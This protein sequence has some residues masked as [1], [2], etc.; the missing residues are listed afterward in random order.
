MKTYKS[1]EACGIS[2]AKV[3]KFVR[4][5]N[6]NGYAMHSVMLSRGD[7]I[8]AEGYWAPFT[9]ET[10]YRMNSVTKS[11]VGIAVGL[12]IED[13]KLAEDDSIVKFFPEYSADEI[14]D[15]VRELTVHD[16]LTMRTTTLISGHWV[17]DK[18]M[19]RVP[20][21][22]YTKPVRP[23][24]TVFRYDST[25][26]YILGVIAE[27]LTGK[28][29]IEY[30]KERLLRKLDFAE[31][32]CCIK[33]PDGYSWG[34]SGLLIKMRD[35]HTFAKFV[36]DGGVFNGEW[37]M[38]EDFIRRATSKI[39]DTTGSGFKAHNTMGYGMQIWKTYDDGFAF[40][41]MGDQL[42]VCV[43]K[44]QFIFICTADNQ[45]NPGSRPVILDRLHHDIIDELSDAPLPEDKAAQDSLKAYLSGMELVSLEGEAHTDTADKVNGV[46]YV[47][48]DNS[49]KLSR[50]RL[51][52]DGGKGSFIY[53]NA[54][55]EKSLDFSLSGNLITEFPEEGYP[56]MQMNVPC[57]GNKYPCAVS[58]AWLEERK[59][60]IR[61][62]MVGKHLGGLYVAIG[63][64]PDLGKVSVNMVKN[65][66][67]FLDT[68]SGSAV[69]I[70]E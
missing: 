27:K 13:G 21:Y 44:K 53:Q 47:F 28:P 15:Y 10:M 60:G 43:P 45:D 26:S 66:N 65:T 38:N 18:V 23:K 41:G 61:V 52:F 31:E 6:D 14:P 4:I 70:R 2:S 12:L 25:G 1:P 51:V 49:M 42:V 22:L 24:E 68:Y 63:F 59:L 39:S 37:L 56:D 57:P 19:D 35:L 16:L 30:M 50:F 58:A 20:L 32:T 40:F 62:Q 67:C 9:S 7:S 8:F 17:R 48:G 34:D 69:G 64:T 5:L 11:F 55:G 3:E 54:T 46:T 29:F 33:G 36:M